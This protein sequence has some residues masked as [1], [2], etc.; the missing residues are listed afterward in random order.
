MMLAMA[1][2]QQ[3]LAAMLPS[4]RKPFVIQQRPT[5]TPG[6]DEYLIEVKAIALNPIDYAQRAYGFPAINFPAIIGSDIAGT[7]LAVGSAVAAEAPQVGARVV[8]YAPSFFEKGAP[9]YGAFQTRALI[10]AE[11]VAPLPD[12]ISFNEGSVLPM[13][14]QTA[15]AGYNQLGI[16]FDL[17]YRAPA[18]TG[19]L[20]WG[21]SS[22]VGCAAVQIG[23][24]L[25]FRVYATASKKNHAYLTTLGAHKLFDYS[26]KNVVA[27]IVQ[28]ARA[29]GVS[30]SMAFLATGDLAPCVAA[31]QQLKGSEAA[32]IVCAPFKPGLLLWKI[33]PRFKGVTAQF[34]VSPSGRQ[35][36][37]AFFGFVFRHWLKEKLASGEVV[38]SPK[39]RVV[40]GGL[41]ALEKSVG[42]F[43]K[44]VTAAKLVLEV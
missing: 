43:K 21:A 26:D 32:R 41:Q 42:E 20:I 36:R 8:A 35:E 30:L 15:W 22:S 18:V 7:V 40:N 10:P 6:A 28:A 37:A 13:A 27:N 11:N 16:P 4:R 33:F 12:N 14:T 38:P 29:D 3:H 34:V 25:G 31:V 1:P 19:V 5:P 9:N 17:G 2:S 23:K 24:I 39:V 44:G